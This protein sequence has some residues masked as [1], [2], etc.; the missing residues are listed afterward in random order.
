MG[1]NAGGGSGRKHRAAP[2][3]AAV[4][5]ATFG[6]VGGG[7]TPQEEGVGRRKGMGVKPN[8]LGLCATGSTVASQD[9]GRAVATGVRHSQGRK[10]SILSSSCSDCPGRD[11]QE[12][13][14]LFQLQAFLS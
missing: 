7:A 3:S 4:T 1:R 2:A 10:R 14:T 8:S 5:G 6:H 9:P 11:G 12:V 13:P